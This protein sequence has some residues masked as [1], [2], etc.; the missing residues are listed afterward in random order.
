MDFDEDSVLDEG[1]RIQILQYGQ[2][3]RKKKR[4]KDEIRKILFLLNKRMMVMIQKKIQLEF[5]CFVVTWCESNEVFFSRAPSN[6]NFLFLL[7][8]IQR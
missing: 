6:F 2:E 8:L 4:E 7:F 3:K 1:S 5:L